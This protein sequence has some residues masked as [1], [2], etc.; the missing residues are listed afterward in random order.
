MVGTT[1]NKNEAFQSMALSLSPGQLTVSQPFLM[2]QNLYGSQSIKHSNVA[3][4][5]KHGC[6]SPFLE[7]AKLQLDKVMAAMILCCLKSCSEQEI[8][9]H[10]FRGF[11][12]SMFLGCRP[13]KALAKSEA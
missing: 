7:V 1:K 8:Q 12:P 10:P 4:L 13:Y 9:L 6:Q 2:L 3:I 11:F 5:Y